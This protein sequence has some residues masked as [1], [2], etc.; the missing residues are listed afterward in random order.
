MFL[1][2]LHKTVSIYHVT[3]HILYIFDI[4]II[5]SI[6][7]VDIQ[8]IILDMGRERLLLEQVLHT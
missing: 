8:Y 1:G 3:K 7:I 5:W 4:L 2:V 6:G